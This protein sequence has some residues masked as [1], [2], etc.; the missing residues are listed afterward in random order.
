MVRRFLYV[1]AVLTVLF[2]GG[3]IAL[4]FWG[5]DLARLAL[6][7]SQGFAA[8]QPLPANAYDAP[9]AWLSRPGSGADDPARFRPAGLPANEPPL[10]AAVFFVHPTSY[11]GRDRWNAPLTD[12]GSDAFAGVMIR[13][14]ASAFNASDA[15]WVPRYRQMTMGGFLADNPASGPALA[16]AYGD[17]RAAFHAFLAATPANRPLVLVGHSQGALL[18]KQL[19][20]DEV[21]GKPLARRVAA[22]YVVGWPVSLSH[23]L[24]RIG[25]P[26][27]A[28]PGQPGCVMSW[29]SFAEP[30]DPRITL[31]AYGRFP[32]LDGQLPGSTP[33]LCSNPLTGTPEGTALANANRGT[34]LPDLTAP[35]GG[36]LQPGMVPAR[37]GPDHFLTIG[38]GPELGEYVLPGNNYHVYDIPLFWAN[39]RIDV[40]ARVAAWHAGRMAAR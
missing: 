38:P 4:A 27:C 35:N 13:G 16:L 3:R 19:L 12:P 32:A 10:D 15:V 1:I 24:P 33:F 11:F 23:D 36:K 5:D 30:A 7:P 20:R 14:M 21:A 31:D 18:L 25:L 39:V 29:L 2:I 9:A 37:C 28:G 34:L 22:A 8:Q 6:V 17:V 26:A 40:A